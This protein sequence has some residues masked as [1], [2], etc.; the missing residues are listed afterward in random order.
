MQL[1]EIIK[2]KTLSVIEMKVTDNQK[3]CKEAFI[4]F[5][6]NDNWFENE[7]ATS[8]DV[9]G[10]FSSA[11]MGVMEKDQSIQK[12]E[13]N[14]YKVELG[15]IKKSFSFLPMVRCEEVLKPCLIKSNGE[16]ELI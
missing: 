6:Q 8:S 12:V 16:L 11:F 15:I 3:K 10:F 5:N 4:L 1:N 7:N 2:N 9:I 14:S 13:C